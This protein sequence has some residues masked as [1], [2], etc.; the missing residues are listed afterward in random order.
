VE[1]IKAQSAFGRGECVRL[2][3][4]YS[5]AGLAR[6]ETVEALVRYLRSD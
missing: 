5:E 6:E 3:I 4:V 2:G 1:R